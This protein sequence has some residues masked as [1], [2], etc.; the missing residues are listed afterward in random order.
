MAK[1]GHT[2]K[3]LVGSDHAEIILTD[4]NDAEVMRF[5]LD[6]LSVDAGRPS[7]YGSLGVTGGE[8]KVLLGNPAHVVRW[9]T[10][11]AINLN[12]RGY[13]SYVVDSPATDADYTPN[14]ATPEWDYRVVYEA[15][16]D[17]DAF[18]AAGFGGANIEY[19]HASPAKSSS[20]TLEVEPGDCPCSDPDGCHDDPPPPGNP[21]GSNDPDAVCADAGVPPNGGMPVDCDKNPE[22]CMVM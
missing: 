12:E 7:G 20:N 11:E 13:A 2:F 6:Y 15:W 16:I 18:G 9:D 1:G 22:M 3:D 8:G 21:C 19:V 17:I 10:S 4:A 5:K 14:S